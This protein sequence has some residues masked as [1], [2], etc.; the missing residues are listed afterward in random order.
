MSQEAL[1]P[2]FQEHLMREAGRHHAARVLGVQPS[3]M[4]V[5]RFGEWP[6]PQSPFVRPTPSHIATY[7]HQRNQGTWDVSMALYPEENASQHVFSTFEHPGLRNP[8]VQFSQEA[9]EHYQ[10]REA[11]MGR[12]MRPRPRD[13]FPRPGEIE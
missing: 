12:Q 10:H 6:Q 2:Q 8:A 5:E 7:R 1:G 9:W 3:E 11:K 13:W 4:S